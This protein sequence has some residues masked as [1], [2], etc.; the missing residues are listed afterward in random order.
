MTS[1]VPVFLDADVL[2]PITLCDTLLSLAET[3]QF[4]LLWSEGVFAEVERNIRPS[5]C[6]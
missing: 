1:P 4:E 3:R 6:Q 2:L 5:I